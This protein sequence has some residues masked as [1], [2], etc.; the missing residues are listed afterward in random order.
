MANLPDNRYVLSC[1]ISHVKSDI[2]V[3]IFPKFK[4]APP[5]THKRERVKAADFGGGAGDPS[6]PF[7]TLV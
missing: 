5:H 6:L 2:H 3:H 1:V 7:E 4:Q